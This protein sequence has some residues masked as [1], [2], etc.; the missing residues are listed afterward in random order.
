ML[1]FVSYRKCNF[2]SGCER[3]DDELVGDLSPGPTE[4]SWRILHEIQDASTKYKTPP[5]QQFS[6]II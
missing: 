1:T 4:N 3:E 5:Q 6:K 2:I